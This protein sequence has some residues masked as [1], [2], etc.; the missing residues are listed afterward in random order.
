[1][2]FRQVTEIGPAEGKS[3]NG[4]PGGLL[5]CFSSAVGGAAESEASATGKPR[6]G[7]LS[8]LK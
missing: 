6:V 2:P 4:L 3:G 7:Q 8:Y 1:M 5:L